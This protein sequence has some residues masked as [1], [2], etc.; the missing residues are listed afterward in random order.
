VFIRKQNSH[1]LYHFARSLLHFSNSRSR[2]S[3]NGK[4]NETAVSNNSC[5]DRNPNGMTDENA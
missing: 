1:L 2:F 4:A 3:K 5:R